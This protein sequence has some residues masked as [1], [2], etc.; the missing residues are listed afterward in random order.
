MLWIAEWIFLPAILNRPFRRWSPLSRGVYFVFQIH[1]YTCLIKIQHMFNSQR[2]EHLEEKCLLNPKEKVF[3]RENKL[4]KKL[5]AL[6][7]LWFFF[8]FFFFSIPEFFWQPLGQH[9]IFKKHS[10]PVTPETLLGRNGW[11]C[12]R[13][14]AHTT[15]SFLVF[16]AHL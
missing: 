4:S 6:M 1:T 8:F 15:H 13:A 2:S 16:S 3:E 5:W 7:A 11:K 14:V 9:F 10:F 12:P